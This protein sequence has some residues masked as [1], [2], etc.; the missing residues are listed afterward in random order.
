VSATCLQHV[1]K[2]RIKVRD[3]RLNVPVGFNGIIDQVEQ[4]VDFV[5]GR[6]G[7]S[8]LLPLLHNL[9]RRCSTDRL[10][11]AVGGPAVGTSLALF[12]LVDHLFEERHFRQKNPVF[13]LRI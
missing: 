4:V 6:V 1:F 3:N 8:A 11:S 5:F 7:R 12:A 10:D 9:E 2:G 13:R